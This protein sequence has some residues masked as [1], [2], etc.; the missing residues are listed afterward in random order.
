MKPVSFF[1]QISVGTVHTVLMA[2]PERSLKANLIVSLSYSAQKLRHRYRRDLKW[3]PK[4][5]ADLVLMH[6]LDEIIFYLC[7]QS[8]GPQ[9]NSSS[10]FL[11]RVSNGNVESIFVIL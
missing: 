7:S 9:S 1:R 6:V 11:P 2:C 8:D 3:V 10:Y 5:S 4:R